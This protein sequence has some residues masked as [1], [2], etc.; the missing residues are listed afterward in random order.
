MIDRR[1]HALRRGA[2]ELQ[3]GTREDPRRIVEMGEAAEWMAAEALG[4]TDHDIGKLGRDQGWDLVLHGWKIDVKWSS[5]L[6]RCLLVSA[7]ITLL[8][9]I[10]VLVVGDTKDDLS[11]AGWAWRR[12]V[13]LCE[14]VHLAKNG[15]P[16]YCF[17][18]KSLQPKITL[19]SGAKRRPKAP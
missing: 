9:D 7:D 4:I 10:Y 19:I 12:D 8:A 6:R 5:N 3:L 11:I 17:P 13:V 18:T 14:L 2:A 1:D 15:R 16:S